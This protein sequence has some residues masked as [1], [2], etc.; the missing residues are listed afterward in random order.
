MAW[1]D[2]TNT[3]GWPSD[4]RG[5]LSSTATA[6][7]TNDTL[8]TDKSVTGTTFLAT[9]TNAAAGKIIMAWDG[10]TLFYGTIT[11]VDATPAPDIIYVDG[12]KQ[13]GFPGSRGIPAANADLKVYTTL[14]GSNMERW[15]ID[16][17]E[18][19]KATAA[20]TITLRDIYGNTIRT[21]TVGATAGQLIIPYTRGMPPYEGNDGWELNGPISAVTSAATTICTLHY[22][23]V[24]TNR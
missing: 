17:L 1:F 14:H 15:V 22:H 5:G 3:A 18:L 19:T 24:S 20:D 16:A 8:F 2:F 9:L 21:W 12:W 23:L 10:T 11:S 7:T 13:W 4:G 6:Y